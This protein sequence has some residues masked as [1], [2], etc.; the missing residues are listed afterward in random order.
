MIKA[1]ITS[2]AIDF[3]SRHDGAVDIAKSKYEKYVETNDEEHLAFVEGE[4]PTRWRLRPLSQ[5]QVRRMLGSTM[6]D[7]GGMAMRMEVGARLLAVGLIGAKRFGTVEGKVVD[8]EWPTGVPADI[9]ETLPHIVQLDL[10]EALYKLCE[11]ST[12][13]GLE[14]EGKSPS[15]SSLSGQGN[16]TKSASAARTVKQT[17]RSA[18][19]EAAQDLRG[20]KS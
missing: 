17:K 14:D 19:N 10:G 7:N 3:I 4:V 8:V 11:G 2:D 20:L 6:V 16:S 9:F 18:A 15:P 13:G 5:T 12:A 1:I